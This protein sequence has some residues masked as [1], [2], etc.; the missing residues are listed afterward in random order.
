MD[1]SFWKSEWKAGILL[2]GGFLVAYYLPVEL[3]GGMIA[4]QGPFAESLLLVRWYAREHVLLCLVPAFFIAGA[5]GVFV[6]VGD[7]LQR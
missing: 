7:H 3:L 2:G 4:L 1:V 5:I 6:G